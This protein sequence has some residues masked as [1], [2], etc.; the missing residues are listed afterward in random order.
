[1]VDIASISHGASSCLLYNIHHIAR[2]VLQL[3]EEDHLI[4]AH[5]EKESTSHGPSIRPLASSTLVRMQ[6]QPL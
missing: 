6:M 5:D 1:M 4:A 2:S 3:I